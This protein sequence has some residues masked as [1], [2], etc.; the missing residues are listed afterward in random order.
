MTEFFLRGDRRDATSEIV[1][2]GRP[3]IYISQDD[4]ANDVRVAL[5]NAAIEA[6]E[7]T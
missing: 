6:E 2:N 1:V 4:K 5:V 3:P 7:Q